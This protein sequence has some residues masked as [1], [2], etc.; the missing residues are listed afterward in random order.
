MNQSKIAARLPFFYGWG[1]V[2]AAGSAFLVR[3]AAASLTLSVFIVPMSDE[4][5]WSRTLIAGAASAAGIASLIIAPLTGWL[6]DRFGARILL[7]SSVLVLGFSTMSLRWATVP[8][9]FYLSYGIGRLIFNSF[10]NIAGSTV[11]NQWFIERRGQASSYLGV[12][13]AVGMGGFPFVAQLLISGTGDWKMAWFWMG[14]GVWVIALVPVWLLVVNRP[15]D[16]GMKPDGETNTADGNSESASQRAEAD[17]QSWNLKEAMRTPTLW[18]LSMAGGLMFF[19]HAGTNVHQVAY[20]R[21]QG[22]SATGAAAAIVVLAIGT[23]L[24]SLFWGNLLDRLPGRVVYALV[25]VMIGSV[26]LGYLLVTNVGSAFVVAG[27]FGFGLGGLIVVPPVVAADYFGRSSMG[28][29]RGFTEPF[30]GI[31]Q[32]AGAIGAGIIFDTTDSYTAA[33]PVFTVVTVIAAGILMF[34]KIPRKPGSAN[35]FIAVE[36]APE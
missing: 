11:V 7:I 16:I 26:T 2:Y 22:I 19:V 32:A 15:E 3:N 13:H 6:V 1:I 5:G 35:N 29:V 23:A 31:G 25:A 24:G 17:Q 30:V 14:I 4:L 12:T 34:T 28:A 10:V 33:F 18:L 21:D 36:A 8:I 9:A 27:L 20:L